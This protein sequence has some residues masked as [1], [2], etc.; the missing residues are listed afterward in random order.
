MASAGLV[1]LY[2]WGYG[3]ELLPRARARAIGFWL[4]LLA[5]ARAT[6]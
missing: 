6:N 4:S 5:R 2:G 1:G 3:L